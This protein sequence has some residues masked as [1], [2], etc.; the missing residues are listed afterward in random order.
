MNTRRIDLLWLLLLLATGAS[1]ALGEA[2]SNASVI[3]LVLLL[4]LAKG[5]VV[6][7]DF[8]GLRGVRRPWPHLVAGWLLVVLGAIAITFI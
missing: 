6:A 3:A 5:H 4:A 7:Q 1:W 8:M 2:D